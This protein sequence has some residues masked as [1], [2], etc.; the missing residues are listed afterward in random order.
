MP[1]ALSQQEGLAPLDP[2]EVAA[3]EAVVQAVLASE[4]RGGAEVSV[5]VGD[6]A[7]LHSLNTAYRGIDRPT[8]VLSFLIE[9]EDLPVEE[10]FLGDVVI[11][12][13]RASAQAEAYGHGRLRELSFL[14]AHGT[15]H[16]LGLD[17]DTPGAEA[18]M[19]RRAEVVLRDLGIGR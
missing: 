19:A 15:L 8:D 10:D 11:S 4:G 14:A 6:D 13:E 1:V 18:E 5:H 16:L 7:L 9:D 12:L 17:D 3:I 2:E